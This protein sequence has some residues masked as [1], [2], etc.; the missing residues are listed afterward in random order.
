MLGWQTMHLVEKSIIIWVH[1]IVGF[2]DLCCVVGEDLDC[3]A[4][5]V[6]LSSVSL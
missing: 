6:A 5:I 4:T 3:Y 1:T 2:V